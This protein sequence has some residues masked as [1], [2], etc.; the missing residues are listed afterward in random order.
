[1]D[2]KLVF[3]GVDCLGSA[4]LL[5]LERDFGLSLATC[6]PASPSIGVGLMRR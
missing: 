6:L 2:F 4:A 5:F 1:L 3:I